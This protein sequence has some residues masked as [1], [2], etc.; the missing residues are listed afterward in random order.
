MLKP[1]KSGNTWT[2]RIMHTI[3][4]KGVETCLVDV[5]VQI[6]SGLV[7]FIIVGLPDKV[8]AESKERI[9]SAF[10]ACG[11]SLPSKRITLNLAPSDLP[12]EGSH[13]DLPIALA[14][15]AAIDA[16]PKDAVQ[17]YLALGELTLNGNISPVCGVLPA[18][19]AA[20]EH[21][22]G[23]IVPH[24][25]GSEAMWASEDLDVL[26]PGSLFELINHFKG[27]Q[28]L[29]R[30]PL[31]V[32]Q[33]HPCTLDYAE[34]KGQ[35][36]AKRAMEIAA[37]GGHHILLNGPPGSGKSMLASRLLSIMPPLSPREFLELSVIQSL[38]GTRYNYTTQKPFRNP[39]HSASMV[40]LVGGG[41]KLKPGEISLAHGGVLFLDEFPEFSPYVLDSLRQPLENGEVNIVRAQYRCRFPAQFQLVAAM[42]PCRCGLALDP[43][44]VC[45]HGDKKRCVSRYRTR[46]SGPLLDRFDMFIDVEP[47]SVHD[48]QTAPNGVPSEKI[49]ERVLENRAVQKKRY[50]AY[51][52]D[53]GDTN[54]TCS[55][56][57]LQE[58]CLLTH[59]AQD[60]MQR[61]LK[62]SPLSARA[63]YRVLR[64]ARTIAD[65]DK[66]EQI[67]K[68]HLAESLSYRPKHETSLP[69]QVLNIA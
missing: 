45:Q 25:S 10:F 33:D 35:E 21:E 47:V 18:A 40:A 54:A 51:D 12:K 8:V 61:F 67:D 22:M 55:D 57:V 31:P 20:V 44:Y 50:T 5:Q 64:V 9:R 24:R 49:R 11:L 23:I 48:L 19:L 41:P 26:A 66:V 7:N 39:H 4:F 38:E 13:F 17:R 36:T 6:S 69:R 65:F 32:I 3:A 15:M 29:S 34:I 2:L 62:L 60:L 58:V 37:A 30:P 63:Y 53:Q 43:N 28:C 27:S 59:S 52:S 1:Q 14:I 56:K 42:N 46:L 68:I 16:I